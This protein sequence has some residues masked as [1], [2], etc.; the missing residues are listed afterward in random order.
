MKKLTSLPQIGLTSTEPRQSITGT[1][2]HW[3]C[4]N[5]TCR[6]SLQRPTNDW[7]T[8]KIV[9]GIITGLAAIA[10]IIFGSSR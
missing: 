8:M 2:E 3:A 7:D 5:T 9:G 1:T 10:A 4:K 6:N